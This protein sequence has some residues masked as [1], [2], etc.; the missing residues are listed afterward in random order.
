M[1]KATRTISNNQSDSHLK[2]TGSILVSIKEKMDF[3]RS[4]G[5]S[6][7]EAWRLYPIS[8][9]DSGEE[10]VI[11]ATGHRPHILA[12]SPE[13]EMLLLSHCSL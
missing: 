1:L 6:E 5:E 9:P 7:N 4:L 12:T 11:A 13:Y 10:P 3:R 2:P 8:L